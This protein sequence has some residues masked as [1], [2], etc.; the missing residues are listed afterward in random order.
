MVS[1]YRATH[2]M[3]LHVRESP[4]LFGVPHVAAGS[5][6]LNCNGHLLF[7]LVADSLVGAAS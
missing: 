4:S 1:A 6:D 3:P 5:C 7:G 2:H